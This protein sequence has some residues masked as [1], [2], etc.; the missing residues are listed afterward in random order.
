M[1]KAKL[2]LKLFSFKK[3]S[4]SIFLSLVNPPLRACSN[5]GLTLFGM[6]SHIERF[7]LVAFDHRIH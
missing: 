5:S 1:M 3:A 7:C 4:G 2:K 6:L